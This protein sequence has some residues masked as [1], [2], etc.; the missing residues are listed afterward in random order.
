MENNNAK[1][2]TRQDLTEALDRAVEAIATVK[3][4]IQAAG[5]RAR[6]FARSIETNMLTAF[7][8]GLLRSHATAGFF[9]SEGQS[10]AKR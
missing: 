9:A 7:Q 3:A 4:E 5:A 1:P 8:S 6:E 10:R 2:I